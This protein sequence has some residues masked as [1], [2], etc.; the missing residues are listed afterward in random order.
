MMNC[1][2]LVSALAVFQ[3]IDQ[4]ASA[5]RT[6]MGSR[7]MICDHLGTIRRAIAD[8]GSEEIRLMR[9]CQV[10]ATKVFTPEFL[11]RVRE[12]ATEEA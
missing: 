5:H 2:M 9:R 7:A 11:R 6:S 10:M 1:V 8:C 4:G 12:L 3:G